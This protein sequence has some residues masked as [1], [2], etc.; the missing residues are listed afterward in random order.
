MEK[1]GKKL[2]IMLM[3]MVV[4]AVVGQAEEILFKDDFNREEVGD[5]WTIVDDVTPSTPS[6]WE[7]RD[8]SLMQLSNI[9]RVDREYEFWQGTHIVAGS[10]KWENYVLSCEMSADDD[11]GIGAIV[12][13][14]D[15]ENY[16]R[17]IMVQ[18]SYNK[19]PFCRLELFNQGE[20]IVL[21]EIDDGYVRNQVYLVEIKVKGDTIEVW[22]DGDKILSAK[23]KT[24]K[25]G[26]IGFM[27]Y[28]TESL[29]IQNVLVK[30]L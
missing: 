5:N 10:E 21:D 11:D 19:G 3:L 28:A 25:A 18:D 26:K 1:L 20:R 22:L 4:V 15:S 23:D 12:R 2:V 6:I 27:A 16:Y 24:I 30:K 29:A 13:Y 9:Y 7:I 14:Q 17:F 8:N